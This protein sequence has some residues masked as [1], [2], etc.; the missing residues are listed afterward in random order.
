[1]AT[2]LLTEKYSDQM[3]GV[4][5]CYDRILI[6]GYLQPF[7]HAKGM[8]NYLYQHQIRIF[9]FTQ[10]AA[11]L[12]EEIR[13]NAEALAQANGL[14]IEFIRKKNFR[15]ED[16]IRKILKTRSGAPGLVHIFSA[17]E[18][19]P[20]YQSW[21]DKQ[22]HKNF[23][24]PDTSKCLT[25]Y[26]YFIDSELGLCFV[27]VP[28]W[29]PFT[30]TVY[31]NGHAWLATQLKA[32][33]LEYE[34]RDNAFT[35]IADFAVANELT[36]HLDIQRLH[37][38]LDEFAQRYCPVVQ[39]LQHHYQWSIRQAEYSTDSVFKQP[40]SLAFYTPL[41]YLLVLC[42]KPDNIAAF[43]GHKLHGNYQGEVGTRFNVRWWG[44]RLKHSLGPVSIKLYDKFGVVLRIET[45]VNDVAFFSQYREVRHRD[46]TRE[47]C[48]A[49]M[50]KTIYSLAPLRELLVAANRRYL[51][52]ISEIETPHMGVP[53]LNQ[54]TQTRAENQHTYKG[55]NF[56]ADEDAALLRTLLRGEFAI[57]G[58]THKALQQA[59]PNKT[60]GQVS[61][62]LKRLRVHGLIKKVGRRYKYYLTDVGHQ[63]AATAL[64]LR[65][66]VVISMLGQPAPA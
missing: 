1:M 46:G 66:I 41:L 7:C 51:A 5:N 19:C 11:P 65:E 47:K 32:R 25:Y 48:Q 21:H 45:T 57:S 61:R 3:H 37:V 4:L 29:A 53:L 6:S 42:V 17:M 16:R 55:F 56:L 64:K 62:L 20:T 43:L 59:L 9:D 12:R 54:L 40:K 14:K 44:R 52:F 30:L 23:L 18:A 26:F 8:T 63:V 36:E 22:T 24:K 50:Q 13:A 39:T 49:K 34:L 10:W 27:R 31:F 2:Q 33:G 35:S 60:S 15:Q 28:T 58:L 38:K